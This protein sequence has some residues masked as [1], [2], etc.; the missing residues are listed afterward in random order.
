MYNKYRIKEREVNKMTVNEM[1]KEL[2]EIA[3]AGF[4]DAKVISNIISDWGDEEISFVEEIDGE[5]RI[6]SCE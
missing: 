2:Q 4:G 5:V 6:F 3:N 1:I